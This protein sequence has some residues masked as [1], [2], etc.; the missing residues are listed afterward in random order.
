M[1]SHTV[2]ISSFPNTTNG[3]PVRMDFSNKALLLD[4][5]LN[6]MSQGVLMFDSETRLVFCN[7]RYIEMYKLSPDV[8]KPGCSLRDLLNYRIAVGTFRAIQKNT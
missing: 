3:S 8:A 5:V 7:Q 6:N 4:T 2:A 1:Y